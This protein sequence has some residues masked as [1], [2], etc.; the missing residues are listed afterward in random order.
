MHSNKVTDVAIIGGGIVGFA[1]AKA[2]SDCDCHVTLLEARQIDSPEVTHLDNRSIALSYPTICALKT[3]GVWEQLSCHAQMIHKIH[4]SERGRYGQAMI[5]GQHQ[6]LPFLGAVIEMPYLHSILIHS[7]DTSKVN[8]IAPAN[9]SLPDKDHGYDHVIVDEGGQKSKLKAKLI[10][11]ADGAQSKIRQSLGLEVVNKQYDQTALVFN[12]QLKRPHHGIAYERFYADGVTAML[13]LPNNRCGCIWT[14]KP[15]QAQYYKNAEPKAMLRHIQSHFGYRLGRFVEMG[16]MGLFPLSLI[17]A[18][19]LYQ[20]NVLL[21]GNAAH[22]LHPVSAQG[23]NLSMRD[24]GVLQQL[25]Q[26]EGLATD[27]SHLLAQY[28][29]HRL[30]DQNRTAYITNG[31]IDLFGLHFSLYKTARTMGLHFLERSNIIKS[32]MN[33]IMMG[34][35]GKLSPIHLNKVAINE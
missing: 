19:T 21:F 32:Q 2:L 10:I 6:N 5:D 16:R 23:F 30:F 28:Q 4:V 8:V 9:V 18:K 17:R 1:L 33:Q 34:R 29:K 3:L 14:M 13:P 24:V 35:D 7:L 22:F 20:H 27:N 26:Q 25:I 31:L 15:E 12:L 11:A